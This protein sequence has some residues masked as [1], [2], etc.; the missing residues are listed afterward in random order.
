[1][2]ANMASGEAMPSRI[3]KTSCLVS[4]CSV[5][6]SITRSH[7][8]RPSK[9]VVPVMRPSM[10]AFSSS[11]IRPLAT[12]RESA[13]SIR[14]MPPLTNSSDASRTIVRYP[15]WAHTCVMPDP[16]NPHPMTPTVSMA[17]PV[18]RIPIRQISRVSPCSILASYPGQIHMTWL[19][20]GH[21][22]ASRPTVARPRLP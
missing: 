19:R 20:N 11:V 22:S 18:L 16:I 9:S 14:P 3:R 17:M 5:T 1:M 7:A 8:A 12:F 13:P 10:A 4:R 15:A 6:A 21:S 2:L